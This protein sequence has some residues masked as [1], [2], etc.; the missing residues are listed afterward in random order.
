MT[1][2]IE[3]E[4]RDGVIGQHELVTYVASLVLADLEAFAEESYGRMD[5]LE[6]RQNA[7]EALTTEELEELERD[8]AVSELL[9]RDGRFH[10]W[11]QERVLALP[12]RK[13]LRERIGA[14]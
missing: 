11:V 10:P 2:T 13:A 4:A 9:D 3:T 1:V 14:F 5:A 7:G 6:A 8:L 12:T